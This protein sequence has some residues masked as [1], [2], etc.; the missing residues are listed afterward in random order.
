MTPDNIGML[1]IKLTDEDIEVIKEA[2]EN[3]ERI[4][5]ATLEEVAQAI[6]Q[7]SYPDCVQDDIARF[8][9][10]MKTDLNMPEK[11]AK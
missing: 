6:E 2:S 3:I 7:Q 5:N 1:T 10:F 11:D 8:V 9:R 4:R